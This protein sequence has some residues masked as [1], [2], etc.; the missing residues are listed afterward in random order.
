M[1]NKFSGFSLIELMVVIVILGVLASIIVPNIINRPDDAKVVKAKQD[2]LAL[3]SALELY[4]L[5]NGTYPTTDQGL[6]AL[7]TP[8]TSEPLA[9]NWKS[10]GYVKRLQNDPWGNPYQYLNPGVHNEV[11]IFS[12][13]KDGQSGGEKMNADIGNWDATQ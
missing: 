8:P 6:S 2:I 7:V 1:Q 12:Y 3:E 4:K 5:D 11:D 13:G 9:N 10:G